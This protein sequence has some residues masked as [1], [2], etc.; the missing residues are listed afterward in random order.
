MRKLGIGKGTIRNRGSSD[1]GKCLMGR[2]CAIVC[3]VTL[4]WVAPGFA[5][6]TTENDPLQ[7][8]LVEEAEKIVFSD[9]CGECHAAEFEVWEETSHATG[10][11]TLHTTDRAKEV[12]EALGLR[13]IKRGSEEATP[14]CLECHYTPTV[15]RG[16]LRAGAGVTC[17]S[18]HGPA[19]DW[20]ARCTTATT[21]ESATS[22]RPR[23]SRHRSTGRSGSTTVARQGCA[24]HLICTTWRRSSPWSVSSA[25][26]AS[27]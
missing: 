27:S 18:C 26:R 7:A 17:E 4:L 5:Q 24:G 20:V 15:R 6:E 14:A 21:R 13:K 10:F 22:R 3:W 1:P 19:R 12:Y 23:G 9:R 16:V 8:R 25:P 11:D 2:V